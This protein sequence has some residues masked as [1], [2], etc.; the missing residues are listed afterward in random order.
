MTTIE[1]ISATMNKVII[2]SGDVTKTLYFS[3]DTLV[4]FELYNQSTF[5]TLA[6]RRD[7]VWGRTTAK[8]MTNFGIKGFIILDED[9]FKEI[10]ANNS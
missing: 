3:Y 9:S 5:F 2:K 8:H 10:V 1:R 6:I 7:N 4:G